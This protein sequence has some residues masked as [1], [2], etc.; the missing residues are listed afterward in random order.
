MDTY[1]RIARIIEF[2]ATDE[3]RTAPLRVV[4]DRAGLSPFHF[5]RLFVDW[6]G[7]SPKDFQ[8]ALTLVQAKQLLA[9][10]I[11]VLDAAISSGLSGP[12]RM[13]DLFVGLESMTPGEYRDAAT[14]LRICW[15]FEATPFGRALFASTERGLCR[16]AFADD[17]AQALDELRAAWPGAQYVADPA[18]HDGAAQE[19]SKRM[20]GEAPQQSLGVLLKGTPLRIK[21]WEALLRVPF[22][23]VASYSSLAAA[24]GE[25]RAVR[26]VAS[27]VAANP[28]A[29]LIP[30][31]RVI[32]SSGAIGD[33]HWGSQRKTVL[34]AAEQ[35]VSATRQRPA[36]M[37]RAQA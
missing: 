22:G 7:I 14:R 30:C 29:Y 6:V 17:D 31:H 3:G 11:P 27:C 9:Q 2:L 37:L 12:S 13:H 25:P 36:P 33:Y 5:Q 21:V 1:T 26:A 10:R 16:I 32:R 15:S 23:G 28:L 4:A 18:A 24:A 8:Q 20:R 19:L 35:A 34:L